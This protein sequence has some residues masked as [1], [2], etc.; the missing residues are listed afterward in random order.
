MP[1][2]IT[3]DSPH[4]IRLVASGVLTGEELLAANQ[5]FFAEN[6]SR[7]GA[8]RTWLSDYTDC[9]VGDFPTTVLH[10]LVQLSVQ[11]AAVN[12]HLV[13]ALA[14]APDLLFGLGRMWDG[15]A[16]QTGW[17]AGVFRTL[18]EAEAWLARQVPDA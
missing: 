12:P 14:A 16:A 8:A 3:W 7:F 18:D 5:A 4:A 1:A 6:L 17:R 10:D 11:V 9:S 2:V 13:V 15:L